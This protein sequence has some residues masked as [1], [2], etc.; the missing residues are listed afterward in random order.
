MP[1]VV[2]FQES[3]GECNH[4]IESEQQHFGGQYAR[5][6]FG[7]QRWMLGYIA[8]IEIGYAYIQ[9]DIEYVGNIE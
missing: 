7:Y 2:A 6:I 1:R 5:Q 4:H 3:Y 9:Q 8:G